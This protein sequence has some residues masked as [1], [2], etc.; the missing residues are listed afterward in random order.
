MYIPCRTYCQRK[1]RTRAPTAANTNNNNNSNNLVVSTDAVLLPCVLRKRCRVVHCTTCRRASIRIVEM[2]H[3]QTECA[4]LKHWTCEQ[5]NKP[6]TEQ[7]EN[8]ASLSIPT[9]FPCTRKIHKCEP[10]CMEVVAI[11]DNDNAIK[12]MTFFL[13]S[14]TFTERDHTAVAQLCKTLWIPPFCRTSQ[15]VRNEIDYYEIFH[16]AMF[17]PR[18]HTWN[19]NNYG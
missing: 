13:R 4:P 18:S 7:P 15:W 11:V 19:Y 2:F 6:D 3:S 14:T 12:T 8:E 1:Y 9:L 16:L 10:H 5:W 17:P